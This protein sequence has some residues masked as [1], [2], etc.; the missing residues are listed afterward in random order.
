MPVR[1]F[2]PFK[3]KNKPTQRGYEIKNPDGSSME[4]AAIRLIKDQSGNN[5]IFVDVEYIDD[6]K[7]TKEITE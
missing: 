1:R 5:K 2:G 4:I 7:K 6:E 3:F